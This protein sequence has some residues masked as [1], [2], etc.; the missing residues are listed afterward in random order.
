M[1]FLQL[2]KQFVLR[3][4]FQNTLGLEH[5]RVGHGKGL[6]HGEAGAVLPG[7]QAHGA[8]LQPVGQFHFVDLFPQHFLEILQQGLV[9]FGDVFRFFLA[10]LAFHV[11]QVQVAPAQG[12]ELFARVFIQCFQAELV[13][14]IQ[15]EQNFETFVLHR[16]HL[17]QVLDGFL[18]LAGS[19]VNRLLAFRHAVRVFFQCA[20]LAFLIG[21]E[22]QQIR[23]LVFFAFRIVNAVVHAGLDGTAVL[24]PE[25]FVFFPL[26]GQHICQLLQDIVFQVAADNFDGVV[27][28]QQFPGNIQGQVRGIHQAFHETQVIRQQILAFFHDEHGTGIQL[29][30]RFVFLE[31]QVGRGLAGDVQQRGVFHGA[32]RPGV[33]MPHGVFP[34]VELVLEELF[35]LF[36]LDGTLVPFPQRGLGV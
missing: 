25:F 24:V 1:R 6:L 3:V 10:G 32:F 27:L 4:Q 18:V 34:F 16:F 22:Q 12:L 2:G 33:V 5:G 17:G 14:R 36:R 15:Q 23:Q 29:Q 31:I 26:F 8:V 13:H 9:V 11:P 20:E 28:L 35:V 19:V 30:A 21:H 7:H